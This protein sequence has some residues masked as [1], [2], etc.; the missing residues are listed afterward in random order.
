MYM[1]VRAVCFLL[2]HTTSPV[3]LKIR[4][5]ISVADMNKI[6]FCTCTYTILFVQFGTCG[7]RLSDCSWS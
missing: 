7:R 6:E 3:G 1:Y 4:D 2:N 5:M